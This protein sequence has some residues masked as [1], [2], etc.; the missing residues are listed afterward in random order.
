MFTFF[1]CQFS[2]FCSVVKNETVSRKTKAER[3]REKEKNYTLNSIR[4]I[5]KHKRFVIGLGLVVHLFIFCCCCFSFARFSRYFT[6]NFN[7]IA[8]WAV[9][10]SL[11]N[12]IIRLK[13]THEFADRGKDS[14]TGDEEDR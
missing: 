7:E 5:E 1:G 3:E 11:S 12:A 10:L 2:E 6:F 4:T 14:Q 8:I 13:N 9:E